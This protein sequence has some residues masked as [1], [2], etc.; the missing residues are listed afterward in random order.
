MTTRHATRYTLLAGLS[1]LV[2]LGQGCGGSKPAAGPDG[3]IFRTADGGDTWA[4]LKVI[5]LGAKQ[6]SIADMGIVTMAADPQDGKALYAG[7]VENGVIYTL[8]DGASWMQAPAPMNVGRVQA[9]AVDAKDKCTVYATVLNQIMKTTTCSRDWTRV[10][11]DPRTDKAFTTLAVDW[12]NPQIVYAGTSDGDILRSENGG[13]SW[14]VVERLDAIRINQLVMDP[15]D[16]RTLYAAT[17]G[18]GVLKTADGGQNWTNIRKEFDAFDGAKRPNLIALDPN[19]AGRVYTVS[20][21]G[22]LLS[23]DGGATW[24]ALQLPTPPGSVDMKA[25]AVDPKDPKHL[26]YAT[27]KAV[28]WTVDSG[29]TWTTKKLPSNRGAAVLMYDGMSPKANV[30]LGAAPAAK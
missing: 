30:F 19:N 29:K 14:R 9:L 12:Y 3:G 28:I 20:K 5:N 17:A 18:S 22:I 21:Y 24:N 16:S 26:V 8:D 25:F 11:Y 13:A 6:A 4:Q 15:R 27:T 7:T 10:Y 1:A 2:L 23:D